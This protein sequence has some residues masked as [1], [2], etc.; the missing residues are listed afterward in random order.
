MLKD[1]SKLCANQ[2]ETLT[3]PPPKQVDINLMF[4]SKLSSQTSPYFAL[5]ACLIL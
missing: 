4:L 3:S 2:I 5:Y 1:V